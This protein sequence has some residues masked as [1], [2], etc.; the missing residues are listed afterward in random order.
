LL[1]PI[2]GSERVAVTVL[3]RQKPGSPEVP[4]LQHWQDTPPEKR[5]FVSPEEFYERHGAAQEEL[6]AVVEYL[7]GKGLRVVDK[8]A[9]RRRIV[10]EGTA[11]EVNA[12]FGVTL[13]RYRV[14]E[15]PQRQHR[16]EG[17]VRPF[18]D[19][20]VAGEHVH[21]G[22]EGPAHLP[23]KLIGVV[24]AVIGLD[25][26]RLGVPA[27][28]GSGDPPGA[29][30]LSPATIAQNYNFPTNK[31][32]GQ[33]IGIFEGGGAAYLHSDITK[34]IQ[35]LPG[36]AALPLPNLA[37]ISLNSSNNPA[38]VTNPPTGSVFECTIDVAIAA[39]SGLGANI[40]VYFS[41]G[42]ETGW[43]D[44]FQRAI[45]PPA[46]DNP[47]S[48][49]T[50]S[51]VPFPSDDSGTVGLL[52]NP[53]SPV[54]IFH[55][56]LRNA[57]HRGITVLMALGDWGSNN[58]VGGVGCHVSYPNCDP[59][60]TSCGGTILGDVNPAPPPK[61]DEWT[62]S[63]ANVASQ[64]D[65]A[66]YDATGGGVSD[67]FHRPPYQIA[68]GVLPIS[69]NDG[70]VRR[71]IPDVAG[72][73]AMTGF[74]T[75]GAGGHGGV[76]TSAVAPLYAG[77][78]ATINAFL[79]RSV[80]F[81]NPTL[82]SYGPQICNDITKGDNDSGNTPDSPFY[83]A[84]IGWDPCTG[85][86]SIN[87]LRLL[88]ALTPAP[89][90]STLIPDSG[91]FG[92]AC[93]DGFVEETLTIDN[94]GFST[95]LI[96]SITSSLS[97]FEIPS[98][99]SYPLAV[100]PGDSIEVVIRF[101]PGA[102]GLRSA[103]IT[104]LSN[105]LFSPQTVK[106][107]GTGVAPTLVL[108][109]A[110]SGNFGN[111][112]V[113][114]FR[115]EPLLVNNGGQCTLLVNNIASSSG[116][117]LVPEILSYPIAV[118]AGTSVSLPIRF[119]PAGFG[120][121]PAGVVITVDSNDSRGPQSIPV[122]GNAPSG[123]L[124]VTGS[125]FF[126]AVPACCREE[127]VISICNVGDCKLNVSSVAFKRKSRHWKLINNPFPAALHPGSCLAVVIRYKATEKYPH[128]CEIVIVSDDPAMPV[129]TLDVLGTTVWSEC[130]CKKCCDTCRKGGCEK[131]H[132]DPCCCHRCHDDYDDDDC[133]DDDEEHD[134]DHP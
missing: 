11:A 9:G 112:C 63:D 116:D 59:F 89:I 21:R 8:H 108:G 104:I 121:T 27:G 33:T 19:H 72:M 58:L 133:Q 117:F 1:G 16:H 35:S 47:P 123:K 53:G 22:F 129:K 42:S 12:T 111:V 83:S 119:Q 84:D 44:F 99:S 118:A 7:T 97:D 96:W 68:A 32:A 23:T 87:G 113:G 38:L 134:A 115:D 43:E 46:G 5:A 55:G 2:D 70:G 109:I 61:F 82:Y 66:P 4:D 20:T 15:R 130:G 132:C 48:V 49:L 14:P 102:V 3:L 51:W 67:T 39:T 128:P 17:N 26:R 120:P 94:A 98:V 76:G 6:D 88:A 95:L 90:V 101:K 78:V 24:T 81:L 13:N 77:L 65:I 92:K 100:S 73:V 124:V 50:A 85:W 10:V 28:T 126:G 75:A 93:L 36:G 29:Q 125:T 25:D 127:R 71:G 69:K 57:A 107:T 86:G 122:S 80:G 62:W 30:Y 103:T 64:F 60:V 41:D 79:G 37:D 18:G 54:S 52:S 110:D 40:N 31:A 45:F 105:D 56:Y 91:D 131:R 106:V 114:S 34:Y 74:F